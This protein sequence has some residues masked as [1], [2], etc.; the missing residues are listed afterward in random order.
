MAADSSAQAS[1]ARSFAMPAFSAI[2]SITA[3]RS[4]GSGPRPARDSYS[5][6]RE[7]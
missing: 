5:A 7:R 4:A 6:N 1:I 2:R 3:R